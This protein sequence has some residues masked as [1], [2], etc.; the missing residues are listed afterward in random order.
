MRDIYRRF[1]VAEG[2]FSGL[3]SIVGFVRHY[4]KV[5]AVGRP[6]E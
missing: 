2:I 5:Y 6:L 1:G 3:S 4:Y